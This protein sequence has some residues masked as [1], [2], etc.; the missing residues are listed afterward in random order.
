MA[1]GGFNAAIHARREG[2]YKCLGPHIWGKG[3][4]F[5]REKEGLLPE[6]MNRNILIEHDM[7]CMNTSF[8]KPNN[9]NATHRHMWATG[10]QGPWDT[11]RYDMAG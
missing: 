5:P 11:D 1:L 8:E 10:M 6:S 7:R 4:V 3:I 2:E 9:K